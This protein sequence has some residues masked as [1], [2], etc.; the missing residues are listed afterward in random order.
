MYICVALDQTGDEY[1]TAANKHAD[2]DFDVTAQEW[3]Q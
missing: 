3:Q 2:V 1:H